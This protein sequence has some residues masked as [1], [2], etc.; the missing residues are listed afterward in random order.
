M[1]RRFGRRAGRFV[2]VRQIEGRDVARDHR[3]SLWAS[4]RQLG[5]S[6]ARVAGSFCRRRC[7]SSCDFHQYRM[8][9]IALRV[10]GC[11]YIADVIPEVITAAGPRLGLARRTHRQ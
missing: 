10:I 7:A 2:Y 5:L 1:P 3:H 4:V 11:G 8:P 9:R 6:P